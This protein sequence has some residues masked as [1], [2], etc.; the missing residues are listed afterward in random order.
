AWFS[1]RMGY[2]H[3]RFTFGRMTLSIVAVAL[4]VGLVV[5]VRLMNA[6]ALDSFVQTLDDMAGRAALSVTAGDGLTL[7][8]D[9]A[10]KVSAIP[11]IEVAAPLVTSVAFPDDSSGELLTVYGVDLTH[12]ADVRLYHK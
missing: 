2:R 12:D 3:F 9:V 10:E 6:A 1:L 7:A 11:E 4:G 8:E 5:A